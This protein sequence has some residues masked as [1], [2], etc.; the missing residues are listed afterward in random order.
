[1]VV[2]IATLGHLLQES[3]QQQGLAA[4]GLKIAGGSLLGRSGRWFLLRPCRR[5]KSDH[6]NR[7]Q[8]NAYGFE[9]T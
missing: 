2:K 5:H 7:Q 9:R 1:M 3:V 8:T 6:E 4:H